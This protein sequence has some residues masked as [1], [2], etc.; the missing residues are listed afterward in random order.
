[1]SDL[2]KIIGIFIAI[3]AFIIA[4]LI[5]FISSLMEG[6]VIDA[7]LQSFNANLLLLVGISILGFVV[8]ILGIIS[9]IK[10]T[11]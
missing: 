4:L 1:M 10:N 5:L 3:P 11:F 2:A 9:L 8:L 6:M 7:I